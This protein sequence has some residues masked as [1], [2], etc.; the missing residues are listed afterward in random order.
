MPLTEKGEKIM[1]NMKE[2]YSDPGKAERVF[3]ASRNAGTISGVD[4]ILGLHGGT[5]GGLVPVKDP[6]GRALSG[7]D[8]ICGFKHK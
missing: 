2:T 8:S 3:Y 1:E 7:V 5:S 4:T 6:S